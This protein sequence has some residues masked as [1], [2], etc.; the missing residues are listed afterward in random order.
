MDPRHLDLGDR[1]DRLAQFALEA[2]LV[3][4]LLDELAGPQLLVLQQF[5][6]HRARLGQA[7]ASQFEPR[8]V[9]HGARHHD[10]ATTLGE[11]VGNVH[12]LKRRD[13]G[14]AVALG[15]TGKQHPV[16]VLDAPAHRH[17]DEDG[18]H[19]RRGPPQDQPLQ[20]R[21][22]S[23]SPRQH[24][25]PATQAGRVFRLT[26]GTPAHAQS[27]APIVLRAQTGAGRAHFMLP[28]IFRL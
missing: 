4:D 20:E 25:D 14:R 22:L 17:H 6:T 19:H 3:I 1:L 23:K 28:V 7:L 21:Q 11:P 18:H 9:N 10:R 26:H 13:D 12:L 2:A 15:D 5:E 16:V 27:G 24:L 8:L